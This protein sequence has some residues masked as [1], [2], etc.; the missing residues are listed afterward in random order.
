MKGIPVL[1]SVIVVSGFLWACGG[2]GFAQEFATACAD[3]SSLNE[4][5]CECLGNR[6]Q[7]QLSDDAQQFLLATLAGDEET[8]EKLRGELGPAEAIEAG[9]FMTE[10]GECAEELEP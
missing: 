5:I 9:L 8:I 10:A 3:A 2:S 6:A 1:G 4:E 7:E